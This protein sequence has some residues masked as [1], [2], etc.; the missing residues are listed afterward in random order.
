M[1]DTLNIDSPPDSIRRHCFMGLV[2]TEMTVQYIG[3]TQRLSG[4]SNISVFLNSTTS[5][6]KL[7]KRV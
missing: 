4:T 2:E 7:Y 3:S 6:L 5:E 1:R